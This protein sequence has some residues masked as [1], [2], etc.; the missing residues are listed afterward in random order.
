MEQLVDFDQSCVSLDDRVAFE[1]H[2]LGSV[3]LHLQWTFVVELV[4][5]PIWLLYLPMS[6]S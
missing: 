5:V 2:Q 1:E 6:L 3:V 4:D